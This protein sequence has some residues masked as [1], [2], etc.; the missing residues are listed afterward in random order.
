VHIL[1]LSFGFQKYKPHSNGAA[2]QKWDYVANKRALIAFHST[3]LDKEITA[4]NF[5]DLCTS[6]V[7][8][9]NIDQPVSSSLFP[10]MKEK[11]AHLIKQEDF[12]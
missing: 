9:E 12:S 1:F 5:S 6:S 4:A 3:A 7:T 11:W 10:R 8:K 2:N